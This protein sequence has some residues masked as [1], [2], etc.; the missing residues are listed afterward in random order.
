MQLSQALLSKLGCLLDPIDYFCE[1]DLTVFAHTCSEQLA[2]TFHF[3]WMR[4]EERESV[5][6]MLTINYIFLNKYWSAAYSRGPRSFPALTQKYHPSESPNFCRRDLNFK[7][8]S[9]KLFWSLW[10]SLHKRQTSKSCPSCRA[11][12]ATLSHYSERHLHVRMFPVCELSLALPGI[13]GTHF[14]GHACHTI[15]DTTQKSY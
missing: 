4:K 13:F 14:R 12:T 1:N 8:Y 3:H 5:L 9:L 15:N 11:P 7:K 2:C 10:L 6:Q